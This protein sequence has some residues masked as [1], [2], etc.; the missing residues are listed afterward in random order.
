MAGVITEGM[1]DEFGRIVKL[2]DEAR[3]ARN[4]VLAAHHYK[5]A[6]SLVPDAAEIYVQLGHSLKESGDFAGAEAAYLHALELAPGDL[7]LHV[8][9]GHFYKLCGDKPMALR[10][11]RRAQARGARDRHMLS[12]LATP[13]VAD[14][15]DWASRNSSPDAEAAVPG[16]SGYPVFDFQITSISSS[17]K[18]GEAVLFSARV[19]LD[20]I[21]KDEFSY[22]VK[23]R[24]LRFGCQV[25]SGSSDTEVIASERGIVSEDPTS[26]TSLTVTF[27]LPVALFIDKKFRLVSMNGVYD[28]K[29]WFSDRGRPF[30]YAVVGNGKPERL[31]L[32]QYYLEHFNTDRQT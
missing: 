6:L 14:P 20:R 28:G 2:G 3:D 21:T 19:D 16:E 11:Y 1:T 10:Y 24:N 25:Y 23:N 31:D 13:G 32:F 7:D 5:S 15:L 29:F 17:R 27:S 8:Q 4:W 26:P 12:Y 22:L 18:E 30:T 9:L